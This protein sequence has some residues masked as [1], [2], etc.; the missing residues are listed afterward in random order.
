M[1]GLEQTTDYTAKVRAS[2]GGENFSD[3]TAE[4]NFTTLCGQVTSFPWKEDFNSLTVDY[5]IPVCWDNDEGTITDVDSKWCYNTSSSGD[6]A[7]HNTSYDGTNCVRFDS[8]NT[9][10]G[11]T[12][13][14]KTPTLRLPASPSMEL[15]FWYKNPE[16]VDFAV[17]ISTDGGTPALR[18]F[19]HGRR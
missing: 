2:C 8:Y 13:Y 3:W 17:Y 16:D 19:L 9:W 11:E 10:G 4:V 5:T 15:S 18:E 12:N 7:A 1:T 14:L 6:G